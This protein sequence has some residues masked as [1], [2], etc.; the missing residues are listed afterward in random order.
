MTKISTIINK[1]GAHLRVVFGRGLPIFL[2]L[3]IFFVAGGGISQHER[4]RIDH[5]QVVGARAVPQDEII[6]ATEV[7]LGGNNYFV[8]SRKNSRLFPQRDVEQGVLIQFP[9]LATVK[10]TRDSAHGITVVVTERKP[11]ALWCGLVA[12]KPMSPCWY[13]DDTG[14]IFDSAPIF[15]DGAY[16]QLYGF[17]GKED[18][19]KPLRKTIPRAEFENIRTFV[20]ELRAEKIEPSR[21]SLSEDGAMSINIHASSAYRVLVGVELRFNKE[22][23]SLVLAKNLLAALPVQFPS[24]GPQQKKLRYIDLRFDNKVF[25]GFEN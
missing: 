24:N 23:D 6:R 5:V 18:A 16:L 14:F 19:P 9:R 3:V 15:S 25:F 8:Y 20:D 10:A 13:L 11:F 1:V 4:W 7:I 17:L 22:Q 2:L 12:V 21:G